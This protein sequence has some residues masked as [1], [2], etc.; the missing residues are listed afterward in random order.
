MRLR[1]L[2]AVVLLA[3]LQGCSS[4]SPS[5][6]ATKSPQTYTESP[7]AVRLDEKAVRSPAVNSGDT[8]FQVLGVTANQPHIAGSHAEVDSKNGQYVR[9]RVLLTNLGRTTTT[10][11]LNKQQLITQDGATFTPDAETMGIKRQ[12]LVPEL[13]A[14][15]RLEFDLW[16]DIAKN[17]VPKALRV[18]GYTTYTVEDPPAVDIPLTTG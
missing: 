8:L 10:L 18:V 14:A 16:Y 6:P 2:V 15:V 4:S 1:S 7:R 3:S 12:P 17:L 13:G 9:I 5:A 11:K